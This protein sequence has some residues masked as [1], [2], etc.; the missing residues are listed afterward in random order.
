MRHYQTLLLCA[1]FPPGVLS[2]G[3]VLRAATAALVART[4]LAARLPPL[5]LRAL[6]GAVALSVIASPANDH[7]DPAPLT[8]IESTAPFAHP[9]AFPHSTGQYPCEAGIKDPRQSPGTGIRQPR[10]R[11]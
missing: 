10:A 1:S 9:L 6:L 3:M 8:V 7:G 11:G 5:D 2:G 4:R